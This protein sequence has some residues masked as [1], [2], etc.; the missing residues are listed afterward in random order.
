MRP[1]LD[2]TDI[3]PPEGTT[4]PSELPRRGTCL[5][6][7]LVALRLGATSFGGPI[8]HIGHFREEYVRRRRW[9]DDDTFADLAALCQVLPGPTSSQLGLCIGLLRSG[10]WGALAAWLG[11]TLPSVLI[12]F[13]LERTLTSMGESAV[14][15]MHGLELAAFAVVLQAVVL[16]GRGLLRTRLQYVLALSSFATI[17]LQSGSAMQTGILFATG[18][19]GWAFAGSESFPA[20]AAP[21][22]PIQRRHSMILL[23]LLG[24]G[25]LLL[26]TLPLWTENVL[27]RAV[28]AFWRAGLLVFGGGH[29][30]LP[31]LEQDLVGGGILSNSTFLAGYGATQAAPGPLFAVASFFGA[32]IGGWSGAALCTLAIFLPGSLLVLGVLPF[33]SRLRTLP[34]APRILAGLQAGV[35][36]ILA[37]ALV[38]PL[39]ISALDG[40]TDALVVA[41]LSTGLLAFRL[42][43]L[44]AVGAGIL[45]S[46][47]I[48]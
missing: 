16:M 17:L 14:P 42:P 11:F 43:P 35:V 3:D 48:N 45:A 34:G 12:L 31:L 30:V 37:A 20:R 24:A 29:V 7:F 21:A 28:A 4:E 9:I 23:G 39:G 38:D 47:L 2:R 27:L 36:G 13:L 44:L 5:E 26:A 18:L 33:W 19:V 40:W 10:P 32:S 25:T 46:L 8:A 22:I 1:Y 6:T 41:L 15:W